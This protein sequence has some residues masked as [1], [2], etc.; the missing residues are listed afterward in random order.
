MSQ[1]RRRKCRDERIGRLGL[2]TG[3]ILDRLGGQ[4]PDLEY[5]GS[6]SRTR[7]ME[8]KRET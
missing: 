2:E 5:Q 7:T 3:G 4:G 8:Y 6:Y 1:G